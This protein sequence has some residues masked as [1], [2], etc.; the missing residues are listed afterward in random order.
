MEG[1][2]ASMSETSDDGGA[3]DV[4][5]SEAREHVGRP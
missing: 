3:A 4:L 5:E 1:K 2:R